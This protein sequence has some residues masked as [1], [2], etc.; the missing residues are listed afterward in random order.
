M[1]S[2]LRRSISPARDRR[3]RAAS[4]VASVR[5]SGCDHS[6]HL[7]Q[8]LTGR[9]QELDV[10]GQLRNAVHLHVVTAELFGRPPFRLGLDHLSQLRDALGR[11]SLGDLFLRRGRLVAVRREQARQQPAFEIVEAHRLERLI[12]RVRR[13]PAGVV[14]AVGL[15]DLRDHRRHP[16]VHVGQVFV[17]GQE[18]EQ[19]LP[20]GL[21]VLGRQALIVAVALVVEHGPGAQRRREVQ[22]EHRV[23]GVAVVGTTQDRARDALAQHLAVAQ[24]Q[25]THHP[26]RIDRLRRAHRNALSAQGFDELHQV[27]RDS[28]GGQ[29]LRRTG[30]ADGHQF[31]LSSPDALI[32]SD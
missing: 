21:D 26:T 22:V 7:T 11:K 5:A 12:R 28:V 10:L 17:V 23:V 24:P 15:D 6:A 19:R 3:R 8:L 18:V 25:H 20:H 4:R 31:S 13:T 14:A 1:R 9:A 30:A 29:R 2:V 32:W 27:A 16:L